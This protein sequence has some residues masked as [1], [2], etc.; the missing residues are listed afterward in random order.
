MDLKSKKILLTGGAGFLGSHV[1]KKLL[2]CGVRRENIFVPRS[3]ELDLRDKKNCERVVLGQNLVIHLAG[4]TG[5]TEFHRENPAKIFYDNLMMGVELM[6]AARLTGVE[7]FVT[8]GSATEYPENAPLPMSEENLW[9]GFPEA[10]HAPYTVA[11]K[12]L[13]VQAQAYRKQY[14][15]NAIHLLLTNMYGPGKEAAKGFVITNIIKR[16][17]EAERSGKNEIEVWGTG[18]PT[19]DFLYVEDAAEGIVLAAEKYDKPEPVNLGSGWEVSIKEIAETICG[20]M[21]FKGKIRWD[22]EK[23]DGQ[24]RRM[25][26]TGRAEREFGFRPRTSLENGLRA[27]IEW[28]RNN[29][30]YEV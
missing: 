7:K 28:Q 10:V 5:D 9:I 13:L 29:A 24:L 8:I 25:L 4:I 27:T 30:Q 17:L 15:F 12:M 14:S 23:P 21:N 2:D 1:V 6:E 22:I 26:D 16:V 18:K 19:R 11:K 3:R 20:L